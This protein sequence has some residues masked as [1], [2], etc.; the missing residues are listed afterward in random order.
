M[1]LH[2]PTVD[3]ARPHLI[4]VYV[5]NR[6]V[7]Y[8]GGADL[9][10]SHDDRFT[11]LSCNSNPSICVFLSS[12]ADVS[13]DNSLPIRALSCNV[14]N[15][16]QACE[17]TVLHVPFHAAESSEIV[18]SSILRDNSLASAS[19][20]VSAGDKIY[21][22]IFYWLSGSIAATPF[23]RLLVDV[24]QV[25]AAFLCG[26]FSCT[27]AAN[28]LIIVQNGTSSVKQ[29]RVAVHAANEAFTTDP[30]CEVPSGKRDGPAQSLDFAVES[31]WIGDQELVI[32]WGAGCFT[33]I[34][35]CAH[36]SWLVSVFHD[37][38]DPIEYIPLTPALHT[39]RI[40]ATRTIALSHH[41]Q[42]ASALTSSGPRPTLP[43]QPPSTPWWCL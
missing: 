39:G 24:S 42:R 17:T 35:W 22:T 13:I 37:T 6:S 30:R 40:H 36:L 34:E 43:Y 29:S 5:E 32:H 4:S 15:Q 18:L 9:I 16:A 41:G 21:F 10:Q 26:Q 38:C 25:K 3:S 12:S 23:A 20:H 33:A 31:A 19:V 7:V 1:W 27:L 2:D 14:P 8:I 28:G 11:L